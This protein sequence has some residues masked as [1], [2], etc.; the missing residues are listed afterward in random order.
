[1]RTLNIPFFNNRV[2]GSNHK[3]HGFRTD[4]FSISRHSEIKKKKIQMF[5]WDDDDVYDKEVEDFRCVL[6]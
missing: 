6:V 3:F 4:V 5:E 1:M 2:R